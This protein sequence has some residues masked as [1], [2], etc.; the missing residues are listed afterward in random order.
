MNKIKKFLQENN[1]EFEVTKVN[2]FIG[3]D[4]I[5]FETGI[6]VD[7]YAMIKVVSEIDE[8]FEVRVGQ[9]F[10]RRAY[11]QEEVIKELRGCL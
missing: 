2:G 6:V 3:D 7:S 8:I 1:F 5:E 4:V 9:G 11:S 10:V